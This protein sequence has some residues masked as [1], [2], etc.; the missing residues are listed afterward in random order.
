MVAGPGRSLASRCAAGGASRTRSPNNTRGCR[1]A[2]TAR[3]ASMRSPLAST[4]ALAAPFSIGDALHRRAEPHFAA[5]RFDRADHG[6]DDGVGAALAERHAENLVGHRFQIGKQR[7]AGD[8]WR[9]IEVHAPDRHHGLE[10]VVLE[11][12]VEPFARRGGKQPRRV[13]DPSGPAR[14]P[15]G[16]DAR[17]ACQDGIGAPSRREDMRRVL[18]EGRRHRA[19]ALGVGRD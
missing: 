10:L 7:A 12:L 13:G 16:E 11:I 4:T 1:L 19:P 2:I 14:P 3:V 15:G 9:E 18:R 5:G 8:V 6:G 17:N